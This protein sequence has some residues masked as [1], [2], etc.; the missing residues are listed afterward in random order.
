MN[1]IYSWSPQISSQSILHRT[2]IRLLLTSLPLHSNSRD[3]SPAP[4]STGFSQLPDDHEEMFYFTPS[5]WEEVERERK[6]KKPKRSEKGK[7]WMEQEWQKRLEAMEQ[8]EKAKLEV[9]SLGYWIIIW[10]G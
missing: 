3:P 9:G 2:D 7:E 4:S 5:A 1:N 10:L 6:A 8:R